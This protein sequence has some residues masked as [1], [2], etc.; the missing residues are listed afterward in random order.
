MET[1]YVGVADIYSH[2]NI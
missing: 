1:P 2:P